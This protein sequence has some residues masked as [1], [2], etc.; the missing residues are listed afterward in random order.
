[1][2]E[3]GFLNNEW[4]EAQRKYWSDWSARARQ[5]SASQNNPWEQ[6]LD[7][8]WRALAP[9]AS[10]G[11]QELLEKTLAQG[12]QAFHLAE[13]F[14]RE[15]QQATGEA[16][17]QA[18]VQQTFG[19]LRGIIAAI[20]GTMN[21]LPEE[22]LS[23]ATIDSSRDYLERLFALPGLGL[24]HR[25]QVQQREMIARLMRYQKAR[26]AYE[27]FLVDLGRRSVKRLQEELGALDDQAES[28]ESARAL[29]DHWVSAC[30]AV[31]GEQAMTP[32]YVKL[33]GELINSQMAVKQQMRDML[34]E[35]FTAMGM[36]TTRAVR[37]LERRAHQDRQAIKSL[38]AEMAEMRTAVPAKE[39]ARV[40]KKN[41][42]VEKRD[43]AA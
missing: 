37:A 34:D 10:P 3:G 27:L 43:G 19:D 38:Q 6:M 2:E 21:P 40:R 36:P 4:L 29:Y 12:R 20:T 15:Q 30:E 17:W 28:I 32:E 26:Q 39:S 7:Q 41:S 13:Q 35:A 5:G 11:I 24:G 14:I 31:Y 42:R 22:L 23:E 16:D 1:M 8:W 33:Y 25:S 9:G 18:A